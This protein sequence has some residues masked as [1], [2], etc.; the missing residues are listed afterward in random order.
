[1][2]GLEVQDD[3]A[4][5]CTGVQDFEPFEDQRGE[6]N[7]ALNNNWK[8]RLTIQIQTREMEKHITGVN[9]HPETKKT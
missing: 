3:R 2:S 8:I 7:A 5:V 1:V 6:E 4:E 9:K